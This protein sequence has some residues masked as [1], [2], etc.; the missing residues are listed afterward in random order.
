MRIG[1]K[2]K[3][4]DIMQHDKDFFNNPNERKL[5]DI[6]QKEKLT[7]EQVAEYR[8]QRE[9]HQVRKFVEDTAVNKRL[10]ALAAN[11][12]LRTEGQGATD[13]I[14]R[15]EIYDELWF[16]KCETHGAYPVNTRL[17]SGEV[18]YLSTYCPKCK[19]QQAVERIFSHSAISKRHKDCEFKNFVVDTPEKKQVVDVCIRY[20]YEFETHLEQGNSLLF[21]GNTGTGKNHL[22]TAIIKKLLLDGHSVLKLKSKEFLDEAWGL[23]PRDRNRWINSLVKPDL[24]VID[25][26]GRHSTGDAANDVFFQ[27]IDARYEAV[28]PNLILSNWNKDEIKGF[29]GE[30]GTRRLKQGACVISFSWQSFY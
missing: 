12:H 16:M 27:L 30:S 13:G 20:A 7:P 8:G 3:G 24:L 4:D 6:S 19:Q 25:E 14:T 28:K 21:L 23:L 26:L 18:R 5:P 17:P 29:L 22:A 2:T 9:L 10:N 1:N 15:K 11:T